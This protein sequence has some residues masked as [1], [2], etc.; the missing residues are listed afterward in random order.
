MR[1][2]KTTRDRQPAVT[3]HDTGPI[4]FSDPNDPVFADPFYALE[5]GRFGSRNCYPKYFGANRAAASCCS[6]TPCRNRPG[7]EDHTQTVQPAKC[8]HGSFR[9]C[10][11]CAKPA[12]RR[13]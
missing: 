9:G 4:D 11:A 5:K 10:K 12:P 3:E 6:M 2:G 1:K 7:A 8:P 13:R